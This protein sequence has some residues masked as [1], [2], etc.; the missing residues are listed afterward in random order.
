MARLT[1][2]RDSR[3]ATLLR[4][5]EEP[6]GIVVL[7]DGALIVA[8]QDKNRL[9]HFRPG[10]GQPAKTWLALENKTASRAWTASSATQ[11]PATSSGPV[12]PTGASCA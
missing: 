8:E 1:N 2:S 3:V 5:L 9:L 12:P 7:P 11:P 4:D 10:S 6:E